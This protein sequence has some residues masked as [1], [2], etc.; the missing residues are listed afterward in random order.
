[1]QLLG[2]SGLLSLNPASLL[3]CH[4]GLRLNSYFGWSLSSSSGV[5]RIRLVRRSLHTFRSSHKGMEYPSPV[6]SL[7]WGH[8]A[9]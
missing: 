4:I 6:L 1:M 9:V 7:V 2:S 3:V 5:D 8:V